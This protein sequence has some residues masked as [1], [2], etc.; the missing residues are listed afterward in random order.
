MISGAQ[1]FLNEMPGLNLEYLEGGT[2]HLGTRMRQTALKPGAP[3]C[4]PR[5]M[6]CV[7]MDGRVGRAEVG[8]PDSRDSEA[9][10]CSS[11]LSDIQNVS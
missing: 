1:S 3:P 8:D 5:A 10:Q 9:T 4:S 7:Q 2:T 11:R 6:S